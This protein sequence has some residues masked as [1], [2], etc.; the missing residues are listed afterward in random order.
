MKH[1][2]PV[3]DDLWSMICRTLVVQCPGQKYTHALLFS[4][5]GNDTEDRSSSYFNTLSRTRLT[6]YTLR[7]TNSIN[8]S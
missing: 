3:G 4:Q 6:E 5:Y 7:N 2:V 1:Q 8:L